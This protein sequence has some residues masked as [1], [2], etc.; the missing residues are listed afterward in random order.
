MSR[1]QYLEQLSE[2]ITDPE[3][4]TY[5]MDIP[6]SILAIVAREFSITEEEGNRLD[7][8]PRASKVRA[9]YYNDLADYESPRHKKWQKLEKS[10][11]NHPSFVPYSTLIRD[12]AVLSMAKTELPESG[13]IRSMDIEELDIQVVGAIPKRQNRVELLIKYNQYK[14]FRDNRIHFHNVYELNVFES[15]KYGLPYIT[16]VSEL[17]KFDSDGTIQDALIHDLSVMRGERRKQSTIDIT[18]YNYFYSMQPF[19]EDSDKY[20]ELSLPVK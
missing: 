17:R 8:Y 13:N 12:R 20:C 14:R 3:K 16:T 18:N 5:L 9:I 10:F 4:L 15:S 11:K 1:F 6:E 2:T 19:T 7:R